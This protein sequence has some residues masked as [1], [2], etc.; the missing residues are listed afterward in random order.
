M[1]LFPNRVRRTLLDLALHH[2]DFKIELLFE[3]AKANSDPV[4]EW[5]EKLW[6]KIA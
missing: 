5:L 4:E 1:E 6:S 3:E 2:N